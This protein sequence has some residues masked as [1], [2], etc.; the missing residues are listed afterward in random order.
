MQPSAGTPAGSLRLFSSHRILRKAS[1]QS[2]AIRTPRPCLVAERSWI[3]VL[4]VLVTLTRDVIG[5]EPGVHVRADSEMMWR[6]SAESKKL[7]LTAPDKALN[8]D[9]LGQWHRAGGK[10]WPLWCPRLSLEMVR[11]LDFHGARHRSPPRSPWMCSLEPMLV[12]ECRFG[13]PSRYCMVCL[14]RAHSCRRIPWYQ[15]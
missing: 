12:E 2:E 4:F 15:D 3:L 1:K 8:A 9:V 5:H 10:D 13:C 11:D 6:G 7:T 14:G